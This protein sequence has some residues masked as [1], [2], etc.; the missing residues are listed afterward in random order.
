MTE[1]ELKSI[2]KKLSTIINS[3]PSGIITV[4]EKGHVTSW[5][6][7]CQEIFGWSEEEILGK[8]NPTVPHHMVDVYHK[9]IREKHN[10]LETKVLRKDNSLVDISISTIPLKDKNGNINC[11][12]AGLFGL[13]FLFDFSVYYQYQ[14]FSILAQFGHPGDQVAFF[15]YR[16]LSG[17]KNTTGFVS[18]WLVKQ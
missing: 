6:P 1:Q 17:N 8:F 11:N 12:I 5:S 14:C 2:N 16:S 7:A 9:T 10:N 3:S 18:H 13:F 4:D 15:F